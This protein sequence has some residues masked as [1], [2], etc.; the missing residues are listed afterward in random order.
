MNAEMKA[1]W[2]EALR[3]G[4][5]GQAQ[6]ELTDWAGNFCCLGVLC[7]VSGAGKWVGDEY[8]V[9]DE[10]GSEYGDSGEVPEPLRDQLGLSGRA[11]AHLV[12]M[13]DTDKATFTQIADWIEANL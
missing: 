4:R 11:Q 3:S 13:N 9:T 7:D 12:D 10:W 8:V 2:V 1:K 5:Y 6:E